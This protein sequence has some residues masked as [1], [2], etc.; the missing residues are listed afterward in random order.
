[1]V[2]RAD[3]RFG[4]DLEPA[5][6]DIAFAALEDCDLFMTLGTSSVVTP[7]STFALRVGLRCGIAGTSDSALHQVQRQG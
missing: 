3:G 6:I 5:T 2:Q 4:E 7:A 1:M